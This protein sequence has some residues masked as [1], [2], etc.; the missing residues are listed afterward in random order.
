VSGIT[1]IRYGHN[2]KIVKP[3]EETV[4]IAE[5]RVPKIE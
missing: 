1:F 2:Q 5:N 4:L 3:N